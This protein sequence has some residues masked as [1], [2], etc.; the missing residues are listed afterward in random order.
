MLTEF[1]MT[2]TQ[3]NASTSRSHDRL[4]LWELSVVDIAGSSLA[5]P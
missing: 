2:I 1:N 3:H 4:R 5:D